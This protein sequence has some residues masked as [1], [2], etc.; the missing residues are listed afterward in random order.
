[1][2]K[3]FGLFTF[4]MVTMLT[5]TL[6]SCGNDENEDI[7]NQVENTEIT[8]VHKIKI[9]VTG[10][11]GSFKWSVNF[12]GLT[13]HD[14]K[15]EKAIVYD[16][17]GQALA[18]KIENFT[19]L[20]G[21]TTKDGTTLAAAMIITDFDANNNGEITVKLEGYIDG[22]LRNTKTY[23]FKGG[24]QKMHSFGFTTIPLD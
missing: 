5:V 13:W 14:N 19:S 1:M 18:E 24:E 6:F 7:F 11:P 3:L 15:A 4:V 23:T 2:K 21:E 10:L 17:N 9:S 20:S 8:A 16:E 12:N 22:K